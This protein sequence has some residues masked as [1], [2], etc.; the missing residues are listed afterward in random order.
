MK[1]FLVLILCALAAAAPRSQKQDVLQF[2]M[3]AADINNNPEQRNILLNALIRQLI[4]YVRRVINNGSVIF[5]FPPLDPLVVEE[6]HLYIPAGLINLD[7]KLRD[8]LITGFGGFE[9]PKS[10]LDLRSMTFDLDIVFPHLDIVAGEYDLVGDLYNAIPLYGKGPARFVIENFRVSAILH[11]KQSEDG[12]SVLLDRISGAS[13]AIPSFKCD[14]NGVIGG[15][16]IDAIVNAITE[17]VLIG[18]VNRFQGAI[19]FIVST[20]GVDIANPFLDQL[21]TW[22]YIAPFIPRNSD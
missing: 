12:A 11:L 6:Y 9:V 8:I 18:Y 3:S 15:G 16:D 10:E 4:A 13:F 14:I 19:S 5:G 22:R 7:M 21:N 20:L 1:L 17:E 2:D